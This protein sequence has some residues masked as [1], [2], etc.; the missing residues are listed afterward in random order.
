MKEIW[1]VSKI[2]HIIGNQSI[3][4]LTELSNNIYSDIIIMDV[5]STEINFSVIDT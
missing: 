1:W 4:L 3:W 5:C 2:L